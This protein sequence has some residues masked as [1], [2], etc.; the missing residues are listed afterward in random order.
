MFQHDFYTQY[1]AWSGLM[2]RDTA[3]DLLSHPTYLP[4]A[5]LLLT[6]LHCLEWAIAKWVWCCICFALHIYIWHRISSL[7]GLSRPERRQFFILYFCFLSV[8]LTIAL[9]NPV[10]VSFAAILAAFPFAPEASVNPVTRFA[11]FKKQCLLFISTIKHITVF[12]VFLALLFKR[13][14]LVIPTGVAVAGILVVSMWWAHIAPDTMLQNFQRGNQLLTTLMHESPGVSLVPLFEP[15]GTPGTILLWIL[16]AFL[17]VFVFLRVTNAFIQLSCLLLLATLP[18]HHHTYDM[19]VAAPVVALLIKQG[20]TLTQLV[21]TLSLS[22]LWDTAANRHFGGIATLEHVTVLYYP[23]VIFGLIAILFWLDCQCKT[24]PEA[25]PCA[26]A[27][28]T[29]DAPRGR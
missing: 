2:H 1:T 19:F 4:H 8:G 17:F 14:R 27:M 3:N 29:H 20:R 9:G 18:I 24:S 22:G 7:C 13:P 16:W 15:L 23:S 21:V 5:W 28:A 12:P 10:I 26:S 25:E 6:P 11:P